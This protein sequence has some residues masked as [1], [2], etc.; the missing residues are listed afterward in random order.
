MIRYQFIDHQ[1][2]ML[3]RPFCCLPALVAYG[4]KIVAVFSEFI[5]QFNGYGETVRLCMV[6]LVLLITAMSAVAKLS[7]GSVLEIQLPV[8][9]DRKGHEQRYRAD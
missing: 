6:K 9:L 7:T 3:D 8:K 5:T 1:F 4:L 2:V